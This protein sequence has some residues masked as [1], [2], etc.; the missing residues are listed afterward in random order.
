[1]RELGIATEEEVGL[2]TLEARLRE[3]AVAS[4]SQLVAFEQYRGW[5]CV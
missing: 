5:A 2:E 1:L 3:G 4:R